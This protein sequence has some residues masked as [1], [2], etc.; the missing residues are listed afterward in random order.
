[1]AAAVSGASG[2]ESRG[3]SS[4]APSGE[5]HQQQQEP[6][7]FPTPALDH[8]FS[9]I[10]AGTVATVCMNPLDLIKVQFQV[11]TST[12]R[13]RAAEEHGASRSSSGGQSGSTPGSSSRFGA[14]ARKATGADVLRD[15]SDALRTIVRR[16]GYVG[17]YRGL[18]PNVVGNSASWG[19]Y[20]LF[21]TMIKEHMSA[22]PAGHGD[23]SGA[24]AKLSAGQHLLA[25]SESGAL[26]ALLTNPIWVVKTRMFTTSKSGEALYAGIPNE[27]PPSGS[28]AALH[29]PLS[30]SAAT[31]GASGAATAAAGAVAPSSGPASGSSSV[32]ATPQAQPPRQTYNGLVDGL[33]KIW[34]LEGMR[35]LYKGAGLAL[36][37]VSNGAIQFM[38]YEELKRWRTG[39]ARRKRADAQGMSVP[40][41]G[42]AIKLDNTEYL[43]MSGAS[44]LAAIAL[45]Y[46]YQVVRSRIQNHGTAH[47]YPNIPTCI[48]L[49]FRHEGMRGFYK[50]MA[51]NAVRILPGTCVT[52][53][54]YENCSWALR[55]LAE[56]R[57]AKRLQQADGTVAETEA[58]T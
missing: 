11:D 20:F 56:R 27:A 58:H 55:G 42:Y 38:T 28:R 37:G 1:M 32:A 21:Y 45:T 36:V 51:A 29:R 44:K 47:L 24:P 10:V 49:T 40:D 48:R 16:D 41:D 12:R 9:G 53:V 8:A 30:T 33:R 4:A 7:L 19:L 22:Q 15:M 6:H 14:M 35:G 54:V 57:E 25:A 34:R 3:A 43:L 17:L 13:R 50:G 46:P 31:V 39:V 23:G 26:T 18:S 52:F 5:Q 2:S